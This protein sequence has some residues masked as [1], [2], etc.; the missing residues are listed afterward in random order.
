MDGASKLEEIKASQCD[1]SAASKWRV[2]TDEAG[3]REAQRLNHAL[4]GQLLYNW[5]SSQEQWKL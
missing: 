5:S 4:G 1:G 2:L 3:E